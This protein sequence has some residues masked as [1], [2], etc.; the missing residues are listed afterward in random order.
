V[1]PIVHPQLESEVNGGIGGEKGRA[2]RTGES[3][4]DLERR[5][6]GQR[7]A[8]ERKMVRRAARRGVVFGF[9]VE[10]GQDARQEHRPKPSG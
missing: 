6:E 10:D 2:E 9:A 4:Q 7:R 1:R 8:E 3:A 5:Q